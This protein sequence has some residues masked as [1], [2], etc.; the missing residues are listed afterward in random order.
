MPFPW[1]AAAAV[2]AAGLDFLGGQQANQAS[3]RSVREQM[4]FQERMSSSSYQRAVKD[5]KAAGLNPALAYQQG[6]ASSP[7][8]ANYEAQNVGAAAGRGL[9][10]GASAAAVAQQ[11]RAD[12]ALKTATADKTTA[13]ANQLKLESM[14]R[15]KAL[16]AGVTKTRAEAQLTDRSSLLKELELSLA[17]ATWEADVAV[18]RMRPQEMEARINNLRA[19]LKNIDAMTLQRRI[20]ARLAGLS[21]P[22]AVNRAAAESSPFKAKV[23][24]FISDAKGLAD[25]LKALVPG[26]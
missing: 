19:E 14:L 15:V 9:Q 21:I 26:M 12:V 18:G 10:A 7:A 16:E 25:I 3:A 24:P 13:E 20:Q 4:A 2:G 6:G 23:S 22:G 17:S 5:M 1:A 8:G 11:T